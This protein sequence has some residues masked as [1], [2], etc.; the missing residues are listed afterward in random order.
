MVPFRFFHR[1]R[2]SRRRAVRPF[3]LCLELLED[4]TV[5][6]GF[7]EPQHLLVQTADGNASPLATAS[8][9]GL[10]PTK[11][12][13]AYGIDQLSFGGGVIPADG[14]GTTIAIV[15]A[16]NHPFIE[17]DLQK[18]NQQ[19]G[20]PDSEFTI[21]NQFGGTE[22][23]EADG[24]WAMEIAL[25]VQWAHAI[26]P[27]AH[28]LLVLA[29]SNSFFNLNQAVEYAAQQPGVVA[30]SM[31]YGAPEFNGETLFND[32]YLTPSGHTGITFI[33][34]SG[35]NGAPPIYPSVSPNVLAI[36]GTTLNVDALGNVL[37]E[38][39]WSGSGG[40]IS[41]YES[42]PDY[43]QGVVTQSATQ[44]TSPDVAYDANPSTGFPVYDSFNNP[45]QTPWS[46]FGGTSASD[47]AVG[48]PNCHCQSGKN[49]GRTRSSRRT[50]ANPAHAL[51][52]PGVQFPRHY[53]RHQHGQSQPLC[54]SRLR[55]GDRPRQSH[56]QQA[57]TRLDWSH[58]I[59]HRD[60]GR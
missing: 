15:N 59:E 6:S 45:L 23:P 49:S 33:A 5:L 21:V 39:G 47:P 48:R 11:V 9:T 38:T 32:I 10:T 57:H 20:L 26:A 7:Y 52:F 3:Q 43:Q 31:S 22:L 58:G 2:S 4:R 14:E 51:R 25:D 1:A 40:G 50:D 27:K 8:P 19:F 56:R 46:Q 16:F 37:S 13:H 29:Q 17:N 36:G 42:Q 41:T 12:R 28:I 24:G 30:I 53:D 44:R 54:G 60:A 55:S 35:D 18:F 34:A